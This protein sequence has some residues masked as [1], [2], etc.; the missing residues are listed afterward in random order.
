[1]SKTS[2]F[3]EEFKVR[4]EELVQHIKRLVHEGNV[5]RIII[6]NEGGHTILEIPLSIGLIGTALLPLWA[7]LGALAALTANYTIQVVRRNGESNTGEAEEM[8]EGN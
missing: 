3:T 8:E 6:K 2:D 7:A 4:G 1:M 5:R